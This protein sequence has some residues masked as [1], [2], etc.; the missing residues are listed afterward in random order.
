M[1]WT[2]ADPLASALIALL[3]T[4]SSWSLLKEA[5]FVLMESTPGHL[6]PS[7][8]SAAIAGLG[9]VDTVHDLHIWT[10]SSGRESLSAHV[11]VGQQEEAQQADVLRDIRNLAHS[12]FGIDHVTIQVEPR[13]FE[14]CD[15]CS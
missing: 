6:D 13:D 1:N 2:W 9:G 10:I 15:P 12:R 7:E 4:Y 11:R 3:I 14:E 5:V 8:V